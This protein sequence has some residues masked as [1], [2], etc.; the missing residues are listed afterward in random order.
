[1]GE[2]ITINGS[3]MVYGITLLNEAPNR[4]AAV[5]FLHYFLG[6]KGRSII[7]KNGQ[8]PLD[9]HLEGPATNLY[10][11]LMQFFKR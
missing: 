6:E 10:D 2:S 9:L 11:K 5:D 7:Q 1:P 8:T 3:S 4:E